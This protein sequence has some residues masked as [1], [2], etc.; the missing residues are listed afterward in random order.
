V[1]FPIIVLA[2]NATEKSLKVGK[3]KYL[4]LAIYRPTTIFALHLYLHVAVNFHMEVLLSFRQP[5]DGFFSK[6]LGFLSLLTFD[7][8]ISGLTDLTSPMFTRRSYLLLTVGV[9]TF[10]SRE[11]AR[12]DFLP[13]SINDFRIAT[14]MSSRSIGKALYYS[15]RLI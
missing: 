4:G 13:S 7:K 1:L 8:S 3:L 9:L 14:S 10:I 15:Y 5:L 6:E 11:M 12:K 2:A